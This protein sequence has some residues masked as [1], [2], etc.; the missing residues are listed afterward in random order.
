MRVLF[1][2]LTGIVTVLAATTALSN[3]LPAAETPQAGSPRTTLLR[4]PP[5]VQKPVIDGVM[6]P[7]E[8]DNTS[9]Q[10]G[11]ISKVCG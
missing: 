8:W 7:G 10:F 6:K 11:G 5:A 1:R 4:L 3:R 9:W 2:H